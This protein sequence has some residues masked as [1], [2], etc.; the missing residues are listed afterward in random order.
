MSQLIYSLLYGTANILDN[1]A[2]NSSICKMK[3]TGKDVEESYHLLEALPQQWPRLNEEN[4]KLISCSNQISSQDANYLCSKFKPY[5]LILKANLFTPKMQQKSKHNEG[6]SNLNILKYSWEAMYGYTVGT[7]RS[8][9]NYSL[10]CTS[11][12]SQWTSLQFDY[13][14]EKIPALSVLLSWMYFQ[15]PSQI[16]PNF[17]YYSWH[18]SQHRITCNIIHKTCVTWKT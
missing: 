2:L 4:H 5:A 18:A 14:R 10:I 11:Y 8:F 12:L 17:N 3:V 9:S 16:F 7:F 15:S 1:I 6:Q 13:L